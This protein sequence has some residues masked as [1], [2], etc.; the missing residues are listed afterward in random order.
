MG[1]KASKFSWMIGVTGVKRLREPPLTTRK[2]YIP[3]SVG[4]NDETKRFMV[5]TT[6][7]RDP[8]F[9]ELLC[10]TADEYG[11]SNKGVLRIPYEAKDFE[12]WM[13]TRAKQKMLRFQFRDSQA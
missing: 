8:D 6:A 2:G 4:M 7:L 9:L 1:G 13:I 3:V 10:K 12:D 5:H 11:F